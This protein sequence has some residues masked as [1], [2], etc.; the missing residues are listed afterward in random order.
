MR[1][2]IALVVAT[3]ILASAASAQFTQ[4]FALGGKL[5]GTIDEP[6]EVD[7][8]AFV[9]LEGTRI[10]FTAAGKNGLIPALEIQDLTTGVLLDLSA[11]LKGLG[12]PTTRISKLELPGAGSYLLRVGGL[13]LTSGSY[14]IT[15]KGDL[16]K[17]SKS[18]SS[19]TDSGAAATVPVF[20]QALA[21][22]TFTAK[23]QSAPKSLALPGS[24]T[25]DGPSGPIDLGPFRKVSKNGKVLSLKNVPLAGYGSYVFQVLNLGAAGALKISIKVKPPKI[26]TKD[27]FPVAS[28]GIPSILPLPI[29]TAAPSVDVQGTAVEA[30]S[31]IRVE[32]GFASVEGTAAPDRSFALNVPLKPN[33]LN[34]LFVTETLSALVP[35]PA[36]AVDVLQDSLPPSSL[37]IDFP[38]DGAVVSTPT[39][40]VAGRVG[41]TLSGFLGLT[42]TVNGIPATVHPGIGTNGSFAAPDVSLASGAPTVVTVL[43]SDALGNTIARQITVTYAVP[44]GPY[45]TAL[46]GNGQSG[47]VATQLAAPVVVLLSHADGSPFA[48]KLVTFSVT[49]S[50]GRLSLDGSPGGSLSVST[51][52]DGAGIAAVF[53]TLGNDAGSANNRVEVTSNDIENVAH[54]CA[55]GLPA[56]AAQINVASGND[57]QAQ[58]GGP[59]AAPLVAWVSDG[60][61]G[62]AG[63]DVAFT[64]TQGEGTLSGGGNSSPQAVTV[65]TGPTG[66][67]S[68]SLT[69]GAEPGKRSVSATFTGYAGSPAVFVAKGLLPDPAT[70]TS[71]AG[72]VLNNA[73]EPIQGAECTLLVGGTSVSTSSDVHGQFLIGPLVAA[74]PAVLRVEGQHA[75]HVGG[76]GGR[77]VPVGS[78]PALAYDVVVVPNAENSLGKP[79]LLPHLDPRNAQRYDGTADVT[80][81]VAGVEGLSMLVKAGSMTRADG[82]MPSEGDPEIL[83][84][85][86]VHHDDVPMPMPDGA[87][88]PFAWT[89]QPAGAHFD[90][91]IEITYPNMSGLPA[92][93]VT[94]FLS[95]DHETGEFEIVARGRVLPDGSASVTEEGEGISVA[96]WG[97]NCPPYSV[98]SEVANTC[99]VAVALVRGGIGQPGASNK[100][101]AYGP[102]LKTAAPPGQLF[103]KDIGSTTSAA[104]QIGQIKSWYQGLHVDG[105]PDP[106]LALVGHSLGGDTTAIFSGLTTALRVTIDPIRHE[107]VLPPKDDPNSCWQ[108]CPY[109]QRDCFYPGPSVTLNRLAAPVSDKDCGILEFSK[110]RGY[111][112]EGAAQKVYPGSDHSTV[113]DDAYGDIA[114]KVMELIPTPAFTADGSPSEILDES[115]AFSVNGQT[116]TVNDD[117]S[118]RISNVAAEDVYGL[119]GP[120]SPPDFL[121]DGYLRVVGTKT[122]DGATRYVFS[123]PFR[124]AEGET[125]VLDYDSL[126]FTDTPPPLPESIE[127]APDAPVIDVGQQT[128][129]RVLAH[130][131]GGATQDVTPQTAWTDYQSS[132]LGIA[133]VD[134]DGV[135]TGAGSGMAF[136]T[137]R[138]GGAT[139]VTKVTVTQGDPLTQVVGIAQL[140]G[141]A[142][143]AGAT[144]TV[145]G[146]GLSATAN[147]FGAFSLAGVPTT[148]G[149]LTVSASLTIGSDLFYGAVMDIVPVVGGPT[150]VGILTLAKVECGFDPELG[151]AVSL[152][153]DSSVNVAFTGGFTFPFLGNVHSNVWVNSNGNLTFGAG[154]G[155]FNPA[156][157][158]G[159]VNGLARISPAFVDLDPSD[160]GQVYVKQLSDRLVVTWFHVPL[161]NA[162]GDNTIQLVLFSNG[163]IH[164]VYN[165]LTANGSSSGHLGEQQDI[166]VAIS[167]GGSPTLQTVDYSALAPFSTEG[168]SAAALENFHGGNLFDLDFRCVVWTPNA[169][170]GFDVQVTPIPAS[171]ASSVIWGQV[172]RP[173]K[174][175]SPDVLVEITSLRDPSFSVVTGTR[176]DGSF[177]VQGLPAPG[178][179]RVVAYQGGVPLGERSVVTWGG[180]KRV[181]VPLDGGAPPKHK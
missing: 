110:L 36:V 19:T 131:P 89:L 116:T 30:G 31:T 109:N 157:P 41:D 118:I 114:P 147:A 7:T 64:L 14:R 51:T 100:L 79:I 71:Y 65:R 135:V 138:N 47:T 148:F 96:G 162:G 43:A 117:G 164:F 46:A 77:D 92:G 146:F 42:V 60:C 125:F 9:G 150:D 169:A 97:C 95:F 18:I 163:R 20:L 142:P 154:S 170:G 87:A 81:S 38:A 29:A 11:S 35:L 74:G 80:L 76:P 12:K 28:S 105:Q 56:P 99:K 57:Q 27:P 39:M 172:E 176:T 70:P 40:L 108:N 139:A 2:W 129:V 175:A 10:S 69:L 103:V 161:F 132:N 133:A 91:P 120:G 122:K 160:G 152:S 82:S 68:T 88:P 112:I 5:E 141:G 73:C 106:K 155:T 107:V 4:S 86:P 59:L 45:L 165:G 34:K 63:V 48:G 144:I 115:W 136:I 156:I 52:T 21:G 94:Y 50:D 168:A 119:G 128:Q 98:T 171:L 179:V 159:V 101:I 140:A 44:T 26:S 23:V 104:A 37:F 53:W 127:A 177:E 90:P 124:I 6:G 49:Q 22:S 62:V 54:F 83:S 93:A 166:S 16:A 173:R 143:A 55:S 3:S 158:T 134:A 130:L 174:G 84:L 13:G 66:H 24:P 15:T 17:S 75:T 32:G 25:L 33:A 78:F 181:V 61:N 58:T 85:N 178:G 167:G 137:A 113:V 145:V 67:A 149:P 123:E 121:S 8:W 111:Q 126:T 72:L 1:I 180:R 151:S 153:D 102:K